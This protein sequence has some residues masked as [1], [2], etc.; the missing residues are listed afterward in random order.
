M[1]GCTRI[2]KFGFTFWKAKLD[3]LLFKEEHFE[4]IESIIGGEGLS[5]HL[6]CWNTFKLK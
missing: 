5:D 4:V 3:W 1:K 6:C 2:A